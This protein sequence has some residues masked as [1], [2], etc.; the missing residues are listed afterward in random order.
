[1]TPRQRKSGIPEF[2]SLE[3]EA[4]FWDTHSFADFEDEFKP[5]RVRF[6]RN[7]SEGITIRLDRT[8]SRRCV[9]AP[10]RKGLARRR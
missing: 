8:R 4:R 9:T 5:V 10:G 6:A 2:A 3:E 1:M 7:L